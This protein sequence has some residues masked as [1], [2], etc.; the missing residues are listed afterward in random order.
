[1]I[2][3]V[4]Y[5]VD[6]PMAR[7]PIANFGLIAVTI[8]FFVYE[9][10]GMSDAMFE[11]MVLEGWNP[12]GL[13]GHMLLHADIVHLVGNMIFLWVFGNAVCA[14]LGNGRYILTYLALGVFAGAIQNLCD[15]H[16]TIGASGAINGIVGLFLVF[17][18]RNLVSCAWLFIIRVGV[19]HCESILMILL[20]LAFDIWG[21]V[22]GGG[23]VAYFAH[24]GGFAGGFGLAVLLLRRGYVQMG[25]TEKSIL[26]GWSVAEATPSRHRDEAST[27]QMPDIPKPAQRDGEMIRLTCPCGRSLRIHQRHAGKRGRCPA[28][29]N[30]LHI[31]MI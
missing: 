23:A 3:L 7:W 6:V 4:P 13:I 20:W 24:L 16:P 5:Q 31:P 26:E 29:N 28:C 1:M 17:Y 2:I 15:G 30:E 12:I 18:P 9:L 11:A 21:V 27:F 14:K 10:N 25:S 19:F 8:L 22:S